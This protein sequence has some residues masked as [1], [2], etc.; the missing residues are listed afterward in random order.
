[1][2]CKPVIAIGET[3]VGRRREGMRCRKWEACI[4][5]RS[6]RVLVVG[7]HLLL[8][9]LSLYALNKAAVLTVTRFLRRSDAG[10]SLGPSVM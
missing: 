2:K 8:S 10:I 6:F 9:G 5:F 1:M 4:V 3:K 7:C